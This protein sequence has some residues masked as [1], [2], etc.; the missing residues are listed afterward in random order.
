M[1]WIWEQGRDSEIVAASRG[2]NVVAIDVNEEAVFCA[3]YNAQQNQL[4]KK[5]TF[6]HGDLFSPLENYSP[7]KI[8][9]IFFILHFI[10]SARQ[11]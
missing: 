9:F 5:M 6:L 4:V 3:Q 11:S 10:P 7:Q 2:A 1:Y 8:D